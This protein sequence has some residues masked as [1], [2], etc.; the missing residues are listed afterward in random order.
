MNNLDDILTHIK[1]QIND[2]KSKLS[3]VEPSIREQL[4]LQVVSLQEGKKF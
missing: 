2:I 4:L 1:S 3:K